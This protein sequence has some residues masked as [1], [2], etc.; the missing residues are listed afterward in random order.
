M[1]DHLEVEVTSRGFKHTAPVP[2]EYG[3]YVK[4]YESSA[5]SGPHL[6]LS[7]TCPSDLNDPGSEPIEAIAHLKLESAEN[8]VEQID[9]LITCHY[10]RKGETR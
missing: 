5:A 6:W 2:S 9:H 4:V 3:G 8:L 1:S 7:V 10:Q